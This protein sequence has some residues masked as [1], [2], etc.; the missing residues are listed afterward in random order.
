MEWNTV[1]G[2]WSSLPALGRGEGGGFIPGD[3]RVAGRDPSPQSSPLLRGA[4]RE[5]QTEASHEPANAFELKGRFISESP[6]W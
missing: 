2:L 3:V 5:S 6:N 4:R 1:S